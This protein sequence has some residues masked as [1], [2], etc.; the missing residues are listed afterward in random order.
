MV[1]IGIIPDGNRRWCKKNNLDVND[2]VKH[3][4]NIIIENIYNNKKKRMSKYLKDITEVSFYVCSIDNINR[5]DN[6]K[7][8]IYDFIRLIYNSY[9]DPKKLLKEHNIEY[10]EEDYQICQEYL[11]EL[12]YNFI[13]EIEL[14]PK[15]IQNIIKELTQNNNPQ[16]KFILNLAIAYDYNKDLLNFER[17][18]FK[19]YDRKQSDIDLIFRSGGEYRTS[20]FFPTKTLYSELFFLKK[21]WPEITIDD[22]INVMKKFQKR[23][24]R[25]GK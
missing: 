11:K 9:K 18:D 6:T 22:F 25:F 8:I 1:H 19:N 15:D 20:G 23:N 16:N 12:N 2:L 24:R 13:G 7:F 21:L 17:T 4:S 10:S 5:N 3:W 14:L